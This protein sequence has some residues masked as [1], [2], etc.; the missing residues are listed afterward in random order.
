[1]VVLKSMNKIFQEH[2]LDNPVFRLV[3]ILKSIN[4]IRKTTPKNSIFMV[5]DFESISKILEKH[6]Q[7]N[8]HFRKIY[9]YIYIYI[10]VSYK[11]VSINN[12]S[13]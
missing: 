13:N 2:F 5:G 1:M 7:R 11:K 3:A 4:Q 6:L 12:L 10:Y 9:I 8:F